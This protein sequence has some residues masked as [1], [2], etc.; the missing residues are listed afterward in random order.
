MSLPNNFLGYTDETVVRIN[1]IKYH[2]W[3]CIDS[4]TRFLT[5]WNLNQA[6]EAE[7]AISLFK[8]A[9]HFSKLL[10]TVYL[11]TVSQ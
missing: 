3:I 9:K 8:Q 6:I 2:I 4:E 5:S 1:G 10:L 11:H 7:C